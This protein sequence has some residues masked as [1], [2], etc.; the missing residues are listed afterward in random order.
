MSTIM[1]LIKGARKSKRSKKSKSALEG[2]CQKKGVII[3]INVMTPKKPNSAQRK[4]ARIKLSNGREV[5][6]YI[7]GEKHSLQSHSVVLI[8]GAAIPD[9]IGV[10]YAVIR[11]AADADG[12][13]GRKQGRSLYGAKKETK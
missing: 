3:A 1:Q 5:T 6:A 2:C 9:L 7:P 4:T 13:K 12:V 11:G 10:N 8:K